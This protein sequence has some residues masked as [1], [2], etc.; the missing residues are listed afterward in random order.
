MKIDFLVAWSIVNRNGSHRTYTRLFNNQEEAERH[1]QKKLTTRTTW[2]IWAIRSEHITI[3]EG[4]TNEQ[5]VYVPPY[6]QTKAEY[7]H[8]PKFLGV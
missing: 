1:Y 8:E 5:G 6:V 3:R 7:I 4:Y 2:E